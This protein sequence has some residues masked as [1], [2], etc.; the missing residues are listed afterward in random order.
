MTRWTRKSIERR[1]AI[2]GWAVPT[3]SVGWAVPT[4]SVGSALRTA[5]ITRAIVGWAPPTSSAGS[6][7]RSLR[8]FPL[9]AFVSSWLAVPLFASFVHAQSAAQQGDSSSAPYSSVDDSEFRVPLDAATGAKVDEMIRRLGSPDH[10]ERKEATN[11]LTELGAKGF[12]RLREAYH[13]TEDFEV[14]TRIQSIVRPAFLEFHV[15]EHFGFLGISQSP[16]DTP[17]HD[18]HPLIPEGQVGI[19][20]QNV[21]DNTGAER[22]GLQAG[23]IV[24]AVDEAPVQGIGARAVQWFGRQIRRRGPGGV[25]ALSLLRQNELLVLQATLG[26]P[27]EQNFENGYIPDLPL[28][29]AEAQGRFPAWWVKH[30]GGVGEED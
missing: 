15:Y 21:L 9:R 25:M 26:R 13:S 27:P 3:S 24:L 7:Q 6:A 19:K 11:K 14:R 22:A 17:G 4:S 12:P 16:N 1:V 2:V 30:F 29:I 18:D 8:G 10:A 23:D 20:I 5:H 28:M